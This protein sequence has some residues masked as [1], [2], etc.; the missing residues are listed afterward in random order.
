VTDPIR[1]T[2]PLLDVVEVFFHAFN[3][4]TELHG[5]AITKATKRSGPTVYGVLDRLENAAWITG[6]WEDQ[7]PESNKPRRR[8][9]RLTPTGVTAAR[10]LLTAHRPQ[11]LHHTPRDLQGRSE[12]GLAFVDW[13]R[14][15]L[16]GSV[17]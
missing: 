13:L 4:D 2:G 9:Y 1:V 5:W 15:V 6:R 17:R 16:S 14:A 12:P 7:H 10:D 8:L 11:A 3:D